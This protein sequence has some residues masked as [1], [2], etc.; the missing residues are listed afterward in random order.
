MPDAV[1]LAVNR[2]ATI[3]YVRDLAAMGAGGVVSYAAGFAE[4]GADGAALQA[5]LREAAGAMPVLGPNCYG[6]INYLDGALLWPDQ[7]GGGRV[8]R[9]VAIVTQSGNIGCNI[10]MQR[11]ALPIAYLVTMGNQAVVGL[12]AAIET[13]ARDARV[14]A[15]GLHIE[16]IDDPAA[17]ARAVAVARAH[18]KPVVVLKTG[19]SAAGAA[20]TVSH[21]ASLA[22]ADGVVSRVPAAPRRGPRRQ[23][24]GAAGNA[25]AAARIWAVARRRHR[26]DELFRRRGGAD[27]RPL[28]GPPH[29]PAPARCR[30][31]ASGGGDAGRTRHRVESARLP[32]LL[33]GQRPGTDGDVHRHAARAIST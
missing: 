19:G 12:S 28:R 13:L 29:P 21:T 8:E 25:E 22:G 23:H 32:H 16:G 26:L 4:A 30:A 31:D 15:I 11:R 17:F 5:A 10:T 14:T 27:R 1:F 3:D 33:L 20:L 24:S 2:H 7:H 9:G 18:G 6:L